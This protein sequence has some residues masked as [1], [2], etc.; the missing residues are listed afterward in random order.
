[1]MGISNELMSYQGGITDVPSQQFLAA[2]GVLVE[3]GYAK[4]L[5]RKPGYPVMGL[6]HTEKGLKRVEYFEI[7]IVL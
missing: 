3:D 7:S 1:M 5:E 2:T 4:R 6:Q